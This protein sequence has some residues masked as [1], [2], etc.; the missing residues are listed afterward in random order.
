EK[1]EVEAQW[2]EWVDDVA[3]PKP[4]R[5]KFNGQLGEIRLAE[6]HG[7]DLN[8]GTAVDAQLE[9]KEN[10][11]R[12]DVHALGDTRFRL[13]QYRIRATTRFR[14]YLPP[15]IY[16]DPELVSKL[17]PVA[18]GEGMLLPQ[19]ID[20]DPGAPVLYDNAYGSH[21]QSRVLATAPP[22]DPLVMY[23]IPTMRWQEKNG[24]AGE[25][26]VTRYGNGLRV[27]L[28]R[29]WFSSGDGEL[30]G[31]VI[32][33]AGEGSFT[34]VDHLAQPYVTQWGSDP[35]WNSAKPKLQARETDFAAR[36]A[37]ESLQLKE[38]GNLKVMVVAHRV[39]WDDSRKLWYCDI[40]FDPLATYM[41]F[42]RLAL[43]RYQPNGM[44]GVKV[45]KVIQADFAQVL[46]NRRAMVKV[47][48]GMVAASLH[49][50]CPLKGPMANEQDQ[51]DM[52]NNR[53]ELILQSRDPLLPSD[54][55]WK[56][57]AMLANQG[58]EI[59]KTEPH[60]GGAESLM[61]KLSSSK[62]Q[63]I[64]DGVKKED[65]IDAP[66]KLG[67]LIQP[68]WL[69][70]PE[71]TEKPFWECKAKLPDLNT[72]H[73]FRVYRLMLREFERY[74]KNAAGKNHEIEERLV[75]A[76]IIDL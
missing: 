73:S 18:S 61:S 22:A 16:E 40:E 8:L 58:Y 71:I 68:D 64:R 9:D 24:Q 55:T 56:D 47:E 48:G 63:Q 42:V 37:S 54:L 76:D 49:G 60:P 20:D 5:V 25:H 72:Q 38:C 31:V 70:I 26:D 36:V 6:N 39:N 67:F 12:G 23:V 44:D 29:P 51:M 75:F 15:S 66:I 28:D 2:S 33:Q 11:Q 1:F 74:Y 57:E 4:E 21:Q 53:V 7:N 19:D 34:A 14:E 3:R 43:V 59:V 62:L 35:F 30:L 52:G 13:I 27:W 69:K 65:L 46:P 45:S 10:A 32:S 17:G 41:P 50:P